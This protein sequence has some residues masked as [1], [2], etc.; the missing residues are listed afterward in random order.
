M[1]SG[2]DSLC[3][4]GGADLN[5][6]CDSSV[7]KATLTSLRNVALNTIYKQR[8]FNSGKGSLDLFVYMYTCLC[9]LK[10][11]ALELCSKKV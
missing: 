1:K 2:D 11:P 3:F 8:I 10:T 7:T 6:N 9:C 5:I 4:L